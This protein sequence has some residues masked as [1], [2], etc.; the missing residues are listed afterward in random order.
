MPQ[1]VDHGVTSGTFSL[2]GQTFEVHNNV[3]VVGDRAV[4]QRLRHDRRVDPGEAVHAA[5]AT[6]VHTGHGADTLIISERL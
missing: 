3:C 2:D 4:V 1:R 5:G 6:V